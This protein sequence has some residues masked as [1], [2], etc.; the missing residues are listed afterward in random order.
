[1]VFCDSELEIHA[2]RLRVELHRLFGIFA[3]ISDVVNAA[4][5]KV[6]DV[7]GSPVFR[8]GVVPSSFLPFSRRGGASG[9][10]C[11]RP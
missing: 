6:S 2:K 8:N 11:S 4:E 9:T 5:F 7:L 1:M 10:V 3:A